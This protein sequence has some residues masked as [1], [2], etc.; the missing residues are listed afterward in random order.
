MI[1]CGMAHSNKL[2][3]LRWGHRFYAC[4]SVCVFVPVTVYVCAHVCMCVCV[5]IRCH[6]YWFPCCPF[7]LSGSKTH[8]WSYSSNACHWRGWDMSY[9]PVTGILILEIFVPRTKIFAGKYG[10]P[11]EKSVQV[12]DAHFRPSFSNKRIYRTTPNQRRVSLATLNAPGKVLSCCS[13]KPSQP[14]YCSN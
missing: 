12:E 2:G 3:K 6:V 5:L 1:Q 7:S 8:K 14:R 10:P 9:W 11:V 13:G 4:I